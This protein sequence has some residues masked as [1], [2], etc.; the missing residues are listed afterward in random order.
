VNGDPRNWCS[1]C[2]DDHTRYDHGHW[3]EAVP[4]PKREERR[5]S[6]AA[7]AEGQGVPARIAEAVARLQAVCQE[8]GRSV[9]VVRVSRSVTRATTGERF[10]R[11]AKIGT[12]SGFVDVEIEE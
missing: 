6:F 8:H 7:H 11:P 2:Q 4:C 9:V 5:A 1:V 3:G 10:I 12:P